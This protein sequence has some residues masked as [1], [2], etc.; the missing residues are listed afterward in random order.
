MSDGV[1]I[2]TE[3]ISIQVVR[4][5]KKQMTL[6]VFRQIPLW[7]YGT[8]GCPPKNTAFWGFVNGITDYGPLYLMEVEGKIWKWSQRVFESEVSKRKAHLRGCIEQYRRAKR[9]YEEKSER[10]SRVFI[11]DPKSPALG[12]LGDEANVAQKCMNESYTVVEDVKKWLI[13]AESDAIWLKDQMADL[14]QLFI[15]V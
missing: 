5:G 9:E 6:A 15:A 4:V 1:F 13:S 12:D 8:D 2:S 3:T 10:A 14:P 7:S 11:S